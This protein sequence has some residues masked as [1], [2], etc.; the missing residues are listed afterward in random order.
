MC[1]GAK[2]PTIFFSLSLK[3]ANFMTIFP[4]TLEYSLNSLPL[5]L[6]LLPTHHK[7]GPDRK[8]IVQELERPG[9]AAELEPQFGSFKK[10]PTSYKAPSEKLEQWKINGP[11]PVYK[12]PPPIKSVSPPPTPEAPPKEDPPPLPPPPPPVEEYSESEEEVES[13]YEEPQYI[14]VIEHVPPVPEYIPPPP[15]EPRMLM[16]ADMIDA[17]R[18]PAPIVRRR[19]KHPNLPGAP[20]A[21]KPVQNVFLHLYMHRPEYGGYSNMEVDNQLPSSSPLAFNAHPAIRQTALPVSGD[22]MS[23]GRY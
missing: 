3:P 20:A 18:Q 19:K 13:E 17:L 16:P 10:N 14:P 21:S 2:H 22:R 8:F 12:P 5:S 11:P 9:V 1:F 7:T 4:K 6:S 23:Y 15:Q